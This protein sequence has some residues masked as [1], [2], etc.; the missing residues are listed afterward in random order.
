LIE[1][2]EDRCDL[3][4]H[5]RPITTASPEAQRWYDLGLYWCFGFNREEA[6]RCFRMAL[7]FDPV[8][9]M[10]HWG[11]AYAAGPFYILAWRE[12]GEVE[13]NASN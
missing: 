12:Y 1:G 9:V 2:P 7:E 10:V 4:S 3:G 13:A 8:C 11:M 6:F 5:S